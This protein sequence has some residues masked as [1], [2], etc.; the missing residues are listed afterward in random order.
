MLKKSF[1]ELQHWFQR[2]LEFQSKN[3]INQNMQHGSNNA[4]WFYVN[5]LTMNI[6][7]ANYILFDKG[8]FAAANFTLKINDI[9]INITRID[10][11]NYLGITST[12]LDK[13]LPLL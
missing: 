7:G 4:I 12:R 13:K 10:C 5:L 2:V 3:I 9:N 6:D 11:I 8:T 1:A